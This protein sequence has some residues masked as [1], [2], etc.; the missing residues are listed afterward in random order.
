M[1][2][3][4]VMPARVRVVPPVISGATS[5]M[6]PPELWTV[7]SFESRGAMNAHYVHVVGRLRHGVPLETA[8]RELDGIAR[9]MAAGSPAQRGHGVFVQPLREALIGTEVRRTSV[10][11]LGV[12]GFLLVMCCANLANLLLARALARRRELAVRA[13][14]GAGRERL[15]RQLMT[16]SLLLAFAGGA[17]GVGIAVVSVPLLARLVPT[18][19]PLA[20]APSVDGR[21]LLWALVLTGLTGVA[22]GVAPVLR[23]ASKPALD[24]LREGPRSGG[25]GKERVRSA[26]V[27]AEI[28]AS[29]VL[30][31]SAG[32]LIRALLTVRGIDPGFEPE[33]V[34]TLRT[35]LP[36]PEYANVAVRE[37]FYA[38]VLGDVRALPGVT[39]AGYVSYLP[40]STFRGGIWPVSVPGD[41]ESAT[42]V[43]SANNVASL[44][45][46]TPGFFEALGIPLKRGRDIAT[47]DTQKRQFVAVVSESFVRRYW[48][49]ED[50]IGRHF[51]FAFA[52][53]EVVG[54]VGDVRFRGLERVSEPQVYLSSQQVQDN[55]IIGYVPRAL[56]IRTRAEPAAIA[57]DVRAIVRRADAKLP[58]TEVQTLADL[59]D[60]ETASRAVQVRVLGAFAAIALV[61]AAVGIHGVLAF[62]VSQRTQEI[63]VRVALGA[64]PADVLWMVARRC[65]LLAAAGVV[66]G[67]LLAYVAGR[68]LRALLAGVQPAD[69]P[70][71]AGVIGLT[72][73]MTLAGSLGPTLRALHVDPLTALRAE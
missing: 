63:G 30:L 39:A 47:A 14:L 3:V 48:P 12:V 4:G 65:L 34:L 49:D 41:A 43:R 2:V 53:R 24:G 18:T 29:V 21:V 68:S 42:G 69:L 9:D 59:V 32:L 23:G 26:L 7:A 15:T 44:R 31:V 52:E 16:E 70:T 55:S 54:V 56:A 27:V 67:L 28:V 17:I 71:L 64:Q 58:T 46:V 8:Q 20:S 36:I 60:L 50:P 45:F 62:T 13:A 25:S 11:L 5:L 37:A 19:L 40:M 57:P 61:L 33:G 73:L 6:P 35:E 66:P 22:F 72:V 1:T 38:R 51:T 10:V